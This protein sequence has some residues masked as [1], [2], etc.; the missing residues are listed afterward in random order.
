MLQNPMVGPRTTEELVASGWKRVEDDG[1]ISQLGTIW[2]LIGDEGTSCGV[3]AGGEHK[4]RSG[5]VH[6]GMLATLADRALGTTARLSHSIPVLAT[7]ELN[8]QYIAAARMGEFVCATGRLLK[9]TSNLAFLAGQLE[10]DGK[11]VAH[12]SGIWLVKANKQ[13]APSKGSADGTA[14]TSQ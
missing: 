14:E 9:R 11:L 3:F 10:S 6:G 7:I 12:I 8:I 2:Q 13:A 5:F 1:F 4:N